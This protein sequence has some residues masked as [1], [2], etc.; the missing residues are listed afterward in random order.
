MVHL[1]PLKYTRAQKG[2]SMPGTSK[3]KRRQDAMELHIDAG[4]LVN[5]SDDPTALRDATKELRQKIARQ[6][7]RPQRFGDEVPS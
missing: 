3:K 6:K 2:P 7:K 1:G 5:L 4:V